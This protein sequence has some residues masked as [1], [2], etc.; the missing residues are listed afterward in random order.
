MDNQLILQHF[1]EIEHKVESLIGQCRS[2]EAEN[3]N[4]RSV[5]ERLEE[6]LQQK[7]EAEK[8]YLD[9]KDQIRTRLDGLLSKLGVAANL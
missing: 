8:R 9:E 6:E 5:I 7:S 2:L 4:L 3:A 1:D